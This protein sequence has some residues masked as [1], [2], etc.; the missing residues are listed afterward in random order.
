MGPQ[1]WRDLHGTFKGDVSAF[2]EERIEKHKGGWSIFA[3]RC[4]CH[5][6]QRDD[7]DMIITDQDE[8]SD[9]PLFIEWV[10]VV[11]SRLLTVYAHYFTG[12]HQPE[13]RG[14]AAPLYGW[15]IVDQFP[16]NGPEPNWKALEE[17]DNAIYEER[18]AK[19]RLLASA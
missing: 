11:S 9:S 16:L 7:G 17:K 5:D 1:L 6:M 3:E 12:K 10:Y 4:Y 8:N 14:Y 13:E 18:E 15:Y 2:I 19:A